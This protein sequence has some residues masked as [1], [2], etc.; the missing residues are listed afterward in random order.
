M[1]PEAAA[2]LR[3]SILSL[4]F[5]FPIHAWKNGSKN[6]IL[7]ATQRTREL[8]AMRDDGWKV[9]RL[10]VVWVHAKDKKQA[11]KKLLAAAS[12]YG[13]VTP[14]GLHEFINVFKLDFKT[15]MN[16]FKFPEINMPKFEAAFFPDT[17]EVS[18]TAK[19]GSTELD[20]ADFNEFK[21]NCPKCGFG[22]DG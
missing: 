16:E 13:E 18:F 2:K 4:G 12:Q 5:S 3:G 19:A 14:E 17:K 11:V 15:V 1:S 9:P 22:F 20:E 21:H 8:R 10:P 7:D 6:Y